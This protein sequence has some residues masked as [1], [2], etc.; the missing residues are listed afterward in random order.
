MV[1]QLTLVYILAVIT[2]IVTLGLIFTHIYVKQVYKGINQWIYGVL[3]ETVA[4][5]LIASRAYL[6]DLFI[7]FSGNILLAIGLL[8]FYRGTMFFI[9][10]KPVYKDIIIL[11]SIVAIIMFT[12]YFIYPIR[13]IRQITMSIF[14]IY[15]TLKIIFST[16]KINN[17]SVSKY[18]TPL[19]IAS[20]LFITLQSIRIVMILAG[21]S[22][23]PFMGS[24]MILDEAIMLLVA[25]FMLILAFFMTIG[26]NIRAVTDL[27]SERLKLEHLSLTDFLTTLPNRRMLM[28]YMELLISQNKKFAVVMIDMDDFKS[29]NDKYGHSMGDEVIKAYANR[30]TSVKRKEDFVARY[31]GDEFIVIIDTYENSQDLTEIIKEKLKAIN[32]T[33]KVS[34][35]LLNINASVGISM[36]PIHALDVLS[37]INYADEALYKVKASGKNNIH[38]YDQKN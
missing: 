19:K 1:D 31:G 34:E 5:I 24:D 36:Y 11:A 22:S 8:Y 25:V 37:M 10:Q 27:K 9:E 16:Y 6:P 14:I 32:S 13:D 4:F 21:V 18:L 28:Q 2:L 7:F 15:I 35:L 38:I 20:V 3:I 30:L 12:F 33:I 23:N 26:V 29:I 17:K